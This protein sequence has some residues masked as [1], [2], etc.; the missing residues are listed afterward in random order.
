MPRSG[1]QQAVRSYSLTIDNLEPN[2]VYG[3][4]A[5]LNLKSGCVQ[6]RA[7]L[8]AAHDC[9][10]L[11][12]RP[13]SHTQAHTPPLASRG[14]GDG[15]EQHEG[16]QRAPVPQRRARHMRGVFSGIKGGLTLTKRGPSA[17]RRAHHRACRRCACPPTN[18]PAPPPSQHRSHGCRC[19]P[20]QRAVQGAGAVATATVKTRRACPAGAP[21]EACGAPHGHARAW[22]RPLAGA[23]SCTVHCAARLPACS[24]RGPPRGRSWQPSAL[25]PTPLTRQLSHLGPIGNVFANQASSSVL[26]LSWLPPPDGGC[27]GSYEVLV[28]W[29]GGGLTMTGSAGADEPDQRAHR[30]PDG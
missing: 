6:R 20:L 11:S 21:G 30:R 19:N 29:Q 23:G 10:A 7:R 4:S 9:P 24:A 26:Y 12:K 25:S 5:V 27:T 18:Q 1:M 2:T 17:R 28:R 22:R 13:P 14:E 8:L 15:R 3:G 16:A